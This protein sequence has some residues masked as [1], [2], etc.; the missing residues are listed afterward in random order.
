MLS[1]IYELP[2]GRGQRWG[3][4]A[5]GLVDGLLGGWQLGGI[6]TMQSG[7]PLMVTLPYDNPNVGEGAKLPNR[8]GDPN[9]GPET[10]EKFFNTD[11]FAAPAP[12]TFGDAGIGTVT[13]PG[14]NTVDLSL[15]KNM[16]ITDRVRLQFRVE[17]FNAFNHL[18]MGDPVT[19]FGTP[20]FG[21]VTSTRLDNRELQFAFRV[22]F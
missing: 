22:E 5:N 18:V 9:T 16:R 7:Q 15:V 10:V 13:G 4:D 14:I 19:D 2:F 21:Q 11:A 1:T 20:L 3:N 17:A 6:W 12:Y 8:V